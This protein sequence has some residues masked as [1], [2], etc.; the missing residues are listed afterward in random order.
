MQTLKF[1]NTKAWEAQ[2]LFFDVLLSEMAEF[3]I[4][5]ALRLQVY[6]MRMRGWA[7]VDKGQKWNTTGGCWK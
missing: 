1:L 2:S 7:G 3:K 6:K 4:E 5:I